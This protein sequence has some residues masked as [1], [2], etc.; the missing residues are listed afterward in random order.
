[1]TGFVRRTAEDRRGNAA[2]DLLPFRGYEEDGHA[3]LNYSSF[4]KPKLNP[5]FSLVL[6][7][8]RLVAPSLYWLSHNGGS[9][10]YL[11]NSGLIPGE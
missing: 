6:S 11:S 2:A 5:S 8:A 4:I 7:S 10:N 3:S 9:K 1:M